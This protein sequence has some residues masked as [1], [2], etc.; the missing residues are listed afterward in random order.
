M[1]PITQALYTLYKT[2]FIKHVFTFFFL[3]PPEIISRGPLHLAAYNKALEE[4]ETRVMRLP[5]MLI[6]QAR[7][8]KTSLRKSLKKEKFDEEEPSTDGI[9]RD[10]SY[11]SVTNEIVGLEETEEEQDADS[12]VSFHNR[13]AK[14][15]LDE[16]KEISKKEASLDISEKNLVSPNSSKL[17]E[18]DAKKGI[19]AQAEE[20]V[21]DPSEEQPEKRFENNKESSD[22]KR[23]EVP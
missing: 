18:S 17:E 12:E 22:R 23:F 15:M 4:G 2:K 16:C 21:A 11:F 20:N 13:I 7:S 5:V 10:P 1:H 19:N 8:G 6:G 14:S 9:E 3:V